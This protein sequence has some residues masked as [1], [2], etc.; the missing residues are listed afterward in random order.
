M[1]VLYLANAEVKTFNGC[2]FCKVIQFP[3]HLPVPFF[4]HASHNSDSGQTRTLQ[5]LSGHSNPGWPGCCRPP[6]STADEVSKIPPADWPSVKRI[7]NVPIP[8]QYEAILNAV[9]SFS[10]IKNA[11][12][13]S[14]V[15]GANASTM[16][17]RT[18]SAKTIPSSSK[19][20]LM[21]Q[22]TPTKAIESRALILHSSLYHDAPAPTLFN[23]TPKFS[24]PRSQTLTSQ[25][26][27][28]YEPLRLE[29]AYPKTIS[30]P[31]GA[32]LSLKQQPLSPD[33]YVKKHYAALRC[34]DFAPSEALKLTMAEVEILELISKQPHPNINK[35]LGCIREGDLIAPPFKPA[36]IIS[37]IKAALDHIHSFGLV[38]DDINPSNIMVDDAGNPI[39]I[40]FD[41]RLA[42]F[43][44]DTYGFELVAK[45]VRGEYD[46]MDIDIDFDEDPVA[47]SP[48]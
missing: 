20:N 39:V 11:Q 2:G 46:G 19:S 45:F 47:V 23:K 31:P 25:A 24:K 34:Y 6:R 26:P 7:F 27:I 18:S 8:P 16:A 30:S 22:G 48:K 37:G 9:S 33:I 44:N 5:R 17:L 36:V 40:D 43:E 32:I 12:T 38:H 21:R 42:A 28:C 13:T 10:R 41:R 15:N 1:D 14:P 35:Y 3:A 29:K 4:D